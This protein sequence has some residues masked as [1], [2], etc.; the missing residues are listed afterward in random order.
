MHVNDNIY[1]EFGRN[2]GGMIADICFIP[3][4]GVRS[5]KDVAEVYSL[6]IVQVLRSSK[7][8]TFG[9]DYRGLVPCWR[10]D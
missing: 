6:H 1:I 9:S 7:K 5:S 2:T 8:G 4:R 3:S 10:C